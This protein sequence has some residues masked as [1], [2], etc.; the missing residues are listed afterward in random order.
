[1]KNPVLIAITSPSSIAAGSFASFHFA[2]DD[3]KSVS[4]DGQKGAKIHNC[5]EK[6][7]EYGEKFGI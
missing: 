5:I 3:N 1:V 6:I 2:Q 4:P 7:E